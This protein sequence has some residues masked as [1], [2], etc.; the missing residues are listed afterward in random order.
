M[1][2]ERHRW[3][4]RCSIHGELS[5]LNYA[6][7]YRPT[8]HVAL[9][10]VGHLLIEANSG[11]IRRIRFHCWSSYQLPLSGPISHIFTASVVLSNLLVLIV[12]AASKYNVVYF[13]Y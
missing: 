13:G 1:R 2:L 3:R 12:Q 4:T 6:S 8:Q 11:V 9:L 5:L 7:A 10:V